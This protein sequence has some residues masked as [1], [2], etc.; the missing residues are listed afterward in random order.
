MK[1]IDIAFFAYAVS[2]M[3]TGSRF[4]RGRARALAKL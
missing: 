2:D 4:L 3:K 1:I